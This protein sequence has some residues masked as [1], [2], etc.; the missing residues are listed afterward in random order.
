MVRREGSA[1][2]DPTVNAALVSQVPGA[3]LAGLVLASLP[4]RGLSLLFAAMVLI[5]VGVSAA[6]WHL[7][8]TRKTLAG[9][10][11]AAGFMGT[12]SGIGGPP[13]ALVYQRASGPTLRATLARFF[14]VGGVVS[15]VVLAVSGQVDG[16]NLRA[17]LVTVPASIAGFAVS[18]P[19]ARRLDRGSVR[20]YVLGLSGV[21]AVAVV[22][23]ELL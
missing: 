22:V 23:R 11:V 1:A 7:R 6:G 14:L 8:P 19:F 16:D 17:C 10:G 4:E 20:P 15:F 21:A 18:A 12:I 13:V 9:A 5:A 2:F 3:L